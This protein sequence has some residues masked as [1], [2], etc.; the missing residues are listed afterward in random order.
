M[1]ILPHL[2]ILWD[3]TDVSCSQPPALSLRY[4]TWNYGSHKGLY[5]STQKSHKGFYPIMERYNS[6]YYKINISNFI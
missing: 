3:Q 6:M 1:S 2:F 5:A 4:G